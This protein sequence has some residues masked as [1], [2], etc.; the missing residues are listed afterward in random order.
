MGWPF[1][2]AKVRGRCPRKQ[3]EHKHVRMRWRRFCRTSS[4][5]MRRWCL[6]LNTLSIHRTIVHIIVIMG[7]LLIKIK[8]YSLSDKEVEAVQ[9]GVM[10]S[11]SRFLSL[12]VSQPCRL[13][14][15]LY[16]T[17]R[18]KW[19]FR[20]SLAVQQ[21]HIPPFRYINFISNS[22]FLTW[23]GFHLKLTCIAPSSR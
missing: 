17:N 7:F 20:P 14:D 8:L 5:S 11:L 6:Y 21:V 18:F 2:T 4:W 12:L 19:W 10:K 9:L 1:L 15:M 16:S 23:F 13:H 3:D 22:S